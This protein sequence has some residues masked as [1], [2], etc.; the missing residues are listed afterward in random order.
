MYYIVHT[1]TYTPHIH[2]H[3]HIHTYT[4]RITEFRFN[5]LLSNTLVACSFA[6]LY[7]VKVTLTIN[8]SSYILWLK[9]RTEVGVSMKPEAEVRK[10]LY[11]ENVNQ[12]PEVRKPL[13]P[14]NV[15]IDRKQEIR[16]QKSEYIY[17]LKM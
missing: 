17:I 4:Q 6:A 10:P 5:I 9:W 15:N 7:C 2:T 14:E 8:L 16:N 13:Y 3:T 12:K 1:H 11:P